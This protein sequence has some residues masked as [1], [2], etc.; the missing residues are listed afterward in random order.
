M[1]NCVIRKNCAII[2][3]I[4]SPSVCPISKKGACMKKHYFL[5]L[6]FLY[7]YGYISAQQTSIT[8]YNN[9]FGV[10]N[11]T[12]KIQFQKGLNTIKI[13]DIP[14][15]IIPTSVNIKLNG[16]VLEQNYQYDL[17]SMQS[18]LNRFIDKEITLTGE[19]KSYTGKLLSTN[20]NEIVL[21]TNDKLISIPKIDDYR[22]E[23]QNIGDDLITR[24]TLLWKVLTNTSG[25]QDVELSYMTQSIKWQAEYVGVLDKDEKNM[26]FNSW[27]SIENNSGGTF[28]DAKLKLIAGDVNL[29]TYEP[30]VL[31]NVM[32]AREEI[33]FNKPEFKQEEFFEYHIYEL[34]N[35]TTISNNEI[36]QI[37][38]FNVPSVSVN[39]KYV[40]SNF[41]NFNENGKVAVV[42]EFMNTKEN[43]LGIPLPRGKV[44]MFKQ[45][46]TANEFIGEQMIDHTTTGEK[47]RI[48]TGNA[49]DIVVEE[50]L[51]ESEKISDQ[52]WENTY[53]IKIKNRKKEDI[54]VEVIRNVFGNWQILENNF[55]YEKENAYR[56][57]F[58]V[59]VKSM[60]ES[61]LKFKVRNK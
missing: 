6:T 48:N 47:I 18:L 30:D 8:I 7:F 36:K 26:S 32:M 39:K 45:R 13:S 35:P 53:S 16:T 38:L 33:K 14:A 51:V 42:L 2:Y 22:I 59:P 11:E 41:S 19:N 5:I 54:T 57:V 25:N 4:F 20:N 55:N 29:Y 49:F 44:K 24:P 9:D 10:I 1:N 56:V 12:R 58:K 61:V 23:M 28:R 21:K 27:V 17:V 34:N 15:K 52:V 31:Y 60:G 40:Y 46:G 50:N 3:A 37:S 43:N